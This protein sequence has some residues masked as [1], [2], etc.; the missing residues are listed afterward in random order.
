MAHCIQF[1]SF[2][3]LQVWNGKEFERIFCSVDQVHLN[4]LILYRISCK[5]KRS[6]GYSGHFHAQFL[7]FKGYLVMYLLS[8]LSSCSTVVNQNLRDM[9]G[10]TSSWTGKEV[11]INNNIRS[12]YQCICPLS[13]YNDVVY[14]AYLFC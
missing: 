12:S 14:I 3:I 10:A 13:I 2:N 8:S 1:E 9:I 11:K 5:I 6:F 4:S 7:V